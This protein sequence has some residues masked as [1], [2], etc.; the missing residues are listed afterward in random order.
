M[1]KRKELTK[2]QSL[3]IPCEIILY[4]QENNISH[5]LSPNKNRYSLHNA[6]L[7]GCNAVKISIDLMKREYLSLRT[8]KDFYVLKKYIN[9]T[10]SYSCL[11]KIYVFTRTWADNSNV[12]KIR[13][14]QMEL[15]PFLEL[16][17]PEFLS[18]QKDKT[19]EPNL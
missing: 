17:F 14:E 16:F 12:N 18:A 10:A 5:S 6:I 19:N 7:V 3:I 15:T 9:L 1:P 4:W 2:L 8:R 11:H 13:I